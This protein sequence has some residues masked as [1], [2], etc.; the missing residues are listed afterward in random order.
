MMDVKSVGK[1]KDVRNVRR[2]DKRGVGEMGR[3]KE[4]E[5]GRRELR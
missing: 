4:R 5:K 3:S 2:G 1:G